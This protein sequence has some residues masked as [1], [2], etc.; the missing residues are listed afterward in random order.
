MTDLRQLLFSRKALAAGALALA[1]SITGL[2]AG[3]GLGLAAESSLSP[4]VQLDTKWTSDKPEKPRGCP[5]VPEPMVNM[6]GIRT[7]YGGGSTQSKI[8]KKAMAEYVRRNKDLDKMA[9]GIARQ[10][11]H[12][13][14][15]REDRQRNAH[16]ILNT[17]S[18]WA[19]AGALLGNLH[20]NDP[21]GQRQAI[22]ITIFN[23]ATFTNSYAVARKIGLDDPD[24]VQAIEGWFRDL[25]QAIIAEFTPPEDPRPKQWRWLDLNANT[26]YWAAAAV[27]LYAS[28]TDDQASFDWAMQV[29][30]DA[31][32]EASDDG[33]LRHELKR[34]GRSLHY[35][36]FAMR[37]IS[38]LVAQADHNGVKLSK[39]EDETLKTMAQFTVKA[40]EDPEIIAKRVKKKQVKKAAMIDWAVAL[41]CHYRETAPD[42]SA[43]LYDL[44]R[45]EGREK[46]PFA[47]SFGC[48]G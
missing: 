16:C 10:L 26:R 33:S 15:Y 20:E 22:L 41:S 2:E 48:S 37:A 46:S 40:Y 14:L 42:L 39:E 32:A 18:V 47:L 38:I 3:S 13:Q 43:D 9:L 34:G 17:L 31:I 12:A 6:S 45:Q 44:V 35:Q 28:N 23:T 24:K 4:A 30:H 29:L 1:L 36:N 11:R 27:S 21:K 25:T 7:F 19:R 8:D 5:A